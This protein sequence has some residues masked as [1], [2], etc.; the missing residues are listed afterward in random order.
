MCVYVDT[1]A[2]DPLARQLQV[3]ASYLMWVLETEFGSFT[4][5][6]STHS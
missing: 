2:L 4:R 5:A 1:Y 3:A 6:V